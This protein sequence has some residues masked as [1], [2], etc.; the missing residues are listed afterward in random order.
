MRLHLDPRLQPLGDDGRQA[1]PSQGICARDRP[2]L[3][4]ALWVNSHEACPDWMPPPDEAAADAYLGNG[5]F[6][7]WCADVVHRQLQ[8]AARDPRYAYGETILT[9]WPPPDNFAGLNA[10]H[11]SS[12][13]MMTETAGPTGP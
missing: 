10:V 6:S 3:L 11:A 4:P 13:A 1:D 2:G 12:I 8:R 5:Y 7:S 9:V